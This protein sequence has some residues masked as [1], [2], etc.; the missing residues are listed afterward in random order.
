MRTFNTLGLSFLLCLTI[1]GCARDT[2]PPAGCLSKKL[3]VLPENYKGRGYEPYVINGERY[4]PLPD[5][6]GFVEYGNASWYG[7]DFHGRPTSSGEIYDMYKISAAHKILPLGTYVQA[8]NLSNRKEI[9]VRINDRGPFVKGRV[10][11]FSYAAARQIGLVNPGVT[12]VKLVA[13]GKK[14]G[15]IASTSGKKPVIEVA[16]LTCGEFTV[17]VGAFKSR[18]NAFR[19]CQRLR[20]YYDNVDV[21]FY[22]ER[23]SGPLYRVRVSKSK[24]LT[25]AKRIEEELKGKGFNEAFIIGL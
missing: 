11:D 16:D 7:E 22:N 17:Q 14:V 24:T 21:Q 15:E 9:I 20:T 19:L 13:L 3:I 1:F 25:E 4:Y 12:R 5:A 23:Y 10:I 6:D 8:I 18:D 2:V